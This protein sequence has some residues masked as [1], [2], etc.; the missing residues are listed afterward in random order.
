M[1]VIVA[2]ILA[3]PR[4]GE[5]Q[6][7]VRKCPRETP[8]DPHGCCLTIKKTR[9]KKADT[10]ACSGG[11]VR[12]AGK[13]CWPG[14]DWWFSVG[15]CAGVP[16]CPRR[17]VHHK[18]TCLQRCPKGK[19]EIAGHCCWPGQDWGA[20]AKRCVGRPRCPSEMD[21]S[22]SGQDC[23]LRR[24]PSASAPLKP[25]PV[26]VKAAPTAPATAP[27]PPEPALPSV[28][29]SAAPEVR[30][31]GP[32]R[33]WRTSV[34]WTAVGLG[35]ASVVAGIV[36]GVLA[37]DKQSEFDQGSTHEAYEDLKEIDEAGKGL[38]R[39]QVATLVA[40]GTILAA[41]VGL[42]LWDILVGRNQRAET[43]ATVTPMLTACGAGVAAQVRF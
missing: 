41:G 2:G 11:K 43:S 15:R 36:L 24:A 22:A 1:V 5:A 23:S 20:G 9:V 33:T 31:Q 35:G 17:L 34:G 39:G 7:C 26:P 38:Q 12:L 13:C 18:E 3:F 37:R 30:D 6:A 10:R 16:R 19:V 42:V 14:Q 21:V 32:G 28:T 29:T 40:G 8:R 4:A 27:V 25:A